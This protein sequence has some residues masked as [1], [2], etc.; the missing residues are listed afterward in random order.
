[1][2]DKATRSVSNLIFSVHNLHYCTTHSQ[3]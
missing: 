2:T 1:V 3:L